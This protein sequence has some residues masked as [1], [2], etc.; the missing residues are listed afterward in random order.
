MSVLAFVSVD[1]SFIWISLVL[2]PL[3]DHLLLVVLTIP[4]T[5]AQS[6]HFISKYFCF[7]YLHKLDEKGI[8]LL[9]EIIPEK[10]L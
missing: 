8:Y 9:V 3:S 5:F 4:P 7:I 10:N 6:V 1:V 2:I